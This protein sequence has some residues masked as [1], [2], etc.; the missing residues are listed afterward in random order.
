MPTQPAYGTQPNETLTVQQC[1]AYEE[2]I[3]WTEDITDLDYIRQSIEFF[4]P[5]RRGPVAW[6]GTGRRVGYSVL[7]GDAPGDDE[8]PGRFVR[9]V[10]WVKH[11]D[12]SEQPQGECETTAPS[13]A[14]DPRTVAPGV[15]GDL[16]ER[17]WGAP[18]PDA[19]QLDRPAH[20]VA[21]L[22][23]DTVPVQD[24]PQIRRELG[25]RRPCA[26][27]EA[28]VEFPRTVACPTCRSAAGRPCRSRLEEK[29][30]RSHTARQD[31]AIW[32]EQEAKRHA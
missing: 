14:V 21:G 2:S 10:F 16:T 1:L 15:W 4:A 24:P 12:R 26:R 32:Q 25:E 23:G 11:N 18:L 27:P 3:V 30:R 19:S 29:V 13:E 5:T 17:A 28:K 6:R 31:L 9:R 7:R 8:M 22:S 20:G